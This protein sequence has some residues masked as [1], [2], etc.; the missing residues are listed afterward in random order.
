LKIK[1]KKVIIFDLDGTLID[2]APDLAEAI[3]Y[4]LTTLN[5]PNFDTDTIHQWVGNGA[6]ILVKRALS[7]ESTIDLSIDNSLFE[8]AL[9]IFLDFYAKNVCVKTVTY[10]HVFE[11][12]KTLK[13]RGY[14][15]TI[16]TNKPFNFVSP[17]L[18]ELKLADF[19]EYILGGDSLSKKKPDPMPLLH[20]CDKFDVSI[21][22]MLMIGDSKNDILSA[23]GCGMQSVGVT[24][25]YNY[26]ESIK[27]YN[28]TVVI[29]DFKEI[30][31]FL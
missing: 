18:E 9:K 3:N 11:T 17:I 1:D 23:N 30:L 26:N 15:L 27:I 25:G 10:P 19:F 21:N 13:N 7:G 6:Q 12:L 16:V 20:I 22:Q 24:Y 31:D 14:R 4:M 2:S 5:R 28:P 29:N 8:K